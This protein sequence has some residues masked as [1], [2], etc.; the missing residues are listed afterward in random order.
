[1]ATMM[2]KQLALSL[3][4]QAP[5]ISTESLRAIPLHSFRRIGVSAR[6]MSGHLRDCLN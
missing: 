5:A 6:I 2:G 3:T 4:G 1:M